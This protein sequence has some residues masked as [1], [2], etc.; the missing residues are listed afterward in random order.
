MRTNRIFLFAITLWLAAA[1]STFAASPFLGTWKLDEAKSKFA[2]GSTKNTKVTYIAARGN[3]MKLTVDGTDKDGKPVHWTWNGR[4]D[5]RSY[6]V[7][8]SS[9]VDAMAL[10]PANERTNDLTAGK[11]GKVVMTGKIVVA[12]DGKSRVVT[13]TTTDAKGKKHTDKAYYTKE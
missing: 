7:K 5:G 6:K 9:S 3:M 10:K 2:P 1:A 8:G 13:T 11:D 12:K 4:F